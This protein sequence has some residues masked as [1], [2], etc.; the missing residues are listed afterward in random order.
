MEERLTRTE[1]ENRINIY[2]VFIISA[3]VLFGT[4][5]LFNGW[6]VA[7][8]RVFYLDDL[9]T[10]NTFM[11]LNAGEFIFSTRANK[12]RV[13]ARGLIWIALK[14]SEG[15]WEI[16][17]EIL[18]M[19]NFFNAILVFAFAYLVQRSAEV[20]RR[21][22][23]SLICG[24]LFIAS[25]FAYYNISELWGIMEGVALAFAMGILLLL[26]LYIESGK[27][28]YFYSATGIYALLLFT[29]ERYFVLFILF[30]VA[31][32]L[33]RDMNF[34]ANVRKMFFPLMALGLFWIIRIVLLGNRAIDGTGGTS[35]S[36][37][38]NMFTAIKYCFSQVMYILG[39]NCGPGYLNGIDANSVPRSIYVL[40]FLNII[41]I[42]CVLSIYL[43][44]MIKNQQF[45]CENLK[46]FVLFITFIALCIICSSIT[47]RVEMRW[48]YVSY[49]AYLILIVHMLHSTLFH[50]TINVNK[51]AFFSLWVVLLLVT[52]QFYRAHYSDIFYWQEKDLSREL[53]DITVEK[54][55][56]RLEN[57]NI[58]IIGG[59]WKERTE[60]EWKDF[61]EPYLES[62]GINVV[63]VENIYEA[64][65]SIKNL[66]DWIVLLEDLKTRRYMDLTDKMPISG[67]TKKYGIYEDNWCDMNCGFEV[68]NSM[69]D[70][71][72]F[73]SLLTLYFP[74]DCEVKGTPDGTIIINGENRIDF[75]LA[76]NLTT[77]EFDLNSNVVNTVEVK[78]NYWVYENTGRSEDGR[79]SSVL[80]VDGDF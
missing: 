22:G 23:L 45:R 64:E 51:I 37:T 60:T 46:I 70:Q 71:A 35:I 26:F 58:I 74:E 11:R 52:E 77:V 13:I 32:F 1:S 42:V 30:C 63:C 59:R 79:V 39:V 56:K 24:I 9:F 3:L 62:A 53:Y 28:V 47:V 20:I 17:D 34:N 73:K 25:R 27:Q 21:C 49:A 54:Y 5:L 15:N 10:V 76:G 36:E 33:Q 31:L 48:I 41:F 12:I 40:I 6:I 19:L 61:F 75:E 78:L 4:N 38:F 43:R 80:K 14:V 50:Y 7:G 44:L 67:V 68:V 57:K 69:T 65:Q 29:H 66:G 55:G 18:L 8:N 2:F 72:T 16:L